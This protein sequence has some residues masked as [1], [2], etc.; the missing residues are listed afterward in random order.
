MSEPWVTNYLDNKLYALNSMFVKLNSMF[1]KDEVVCY[2]MQSV[3]APCHQAA[4]PRAA[5]KKAPT[6]ST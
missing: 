2:A 5:V 4:G 1:V 3:V 6:R